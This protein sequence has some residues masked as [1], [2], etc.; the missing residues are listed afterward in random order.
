MSFNADPFGIAIGIIL[1]T[2]LA[3]VWFLRL[4]RP[5]SYPMVTPLSIGALCV[6]WV[7]VQAPTV[8]PWFWDPSKSY[9]HALFFI[10]LVG[11]A[12]LL[13][14]FGG[15]ELQGSNDDD[16]DGLPIP[17]PKFHEEAR[18]FRDAA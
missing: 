1:P 14:A 6:F 7:M 10:L 11:I 15:K 12:S 13:E 17:N 2:I 5:L 18:I 16:Q 3:F 4:L 8:G 9:A